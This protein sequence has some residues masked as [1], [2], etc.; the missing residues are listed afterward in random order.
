[1]DAFFLT[2]CVRGLEVT[3]HYTTRQATQVVTML[4]SAIAV[5]GLIIGV[6]LL[7]SAWRART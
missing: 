6:A 4:S 7:H 1:V 2:C 3:R 5:A